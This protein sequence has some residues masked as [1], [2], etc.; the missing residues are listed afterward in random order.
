MDATTIAEGL[1]IARLSWQRKHHGWKRYPGGVRQICDGIIEDCWNGDFYQASAGHFAQF[2]TRDFSIASSAL[3]QERAEAT[4]SYALQK[5]HQAGAV[6]VAITPR[7]VP[8]DFPV[9]S[10]DSLAFLLHALRIAQAD[11]VLAAHQDFIEAQVDSW[12]KRVIGEDGFVRSGVHFGGMRD[13]AIR[14]S[15]CYDNVMVLLLKQEAKTLG[16][17]APK[18]ALSTRMFMDEFWQ[19]GSFKDARDDASIQGDANVIPFWTGVVDDKQKARQALNTLHR[20]KMDTPVPLAYSPT[21]GKAP[22]GRLHSKRPLE[23]GPQSIAPKMIWQNLFV[24]NWECESRWMQLGLMYVA[25]A[26]KYNPSLYD[27]IAASLR[28][29]I[30][31]NQNVL[32]VFTPDGK[33]YTSAF[34]HADEGMLWGAA[35]AKKIL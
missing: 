30:L 23:H 6:T 20:L 5:F 2:Y 17:R 9:F 11:D 16:L 18:I 13:H 1:R 32:E 14:S 26:K 25:L 22:R 10:P 7:G 24:R 35:L 33:P 27:E 3:P 28:K 4:L 15:S 21:C 31:A 8:F 34:Y 29:N 19:D 12:C